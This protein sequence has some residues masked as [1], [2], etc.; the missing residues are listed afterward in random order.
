MKIFIG[1][2]GS[3]CSIAAVTSVAQ[4]PWP[5][6]TQML[7]SRSFSIVGMKSVLPCLTRNKRKVSNQINLSQWSLI[8]TKEHGRPSALEAGALEPRARL[9]GTQAARSRSQCFLILRRGSCA[10]LPHGFFLLCPS[11]T[12]MQH[13]QN[14]LPLTRRVPGIW[15]GR[16]DLNSRPPAP[17]TDV[18]PLGSPSFSIL[19]LKRNE[20]EKYLVVARCAETCL[21]MYGVP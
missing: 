18:L 4:R 15:S 2:D 21:H 1:T 6:G 7:R 3:D 9:L 20:L 19:L 16:G 13:H 10:A 17:K 11:C 8:S 14:S 12:T 5:P